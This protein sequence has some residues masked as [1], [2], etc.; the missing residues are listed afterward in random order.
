ML[1]LEHHLSIILSYST[2]E[3]S[4]RRLILPEL[5]ALKK[6]DQHREREQLRETGDSYF[7]VITNP[8]SDSTRRRS[9]S[10]ERTPTLAGC[11]SRRRSRSRERSIISSTLS[12]AGSRDPPCVSAAEPLT[13]LSRRRRRSREGR[14]V[15]QEPIPE[16]SYRF[17]E[18][19]DEESARPRW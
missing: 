13:P 9:Q 8:S 1:G 11:F 5:S 3:D 14:S 12:E 6:E 16:R 15:K 10:R 2:V 17:D 18:S 7:E 4:I 19:S